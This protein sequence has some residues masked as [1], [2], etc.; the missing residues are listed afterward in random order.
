M[1][2]IN[3]QYANI[4]QISVQSPDIYIVVL[5]TNS[6]D[7]F[8]GSVYISCSINNRTLDD[9]RL[10]KRI[11]LLYEAFRQEQL[12]KPHLE[13]ILTGNFNRWDALWGGDKIVLHS[14]H[15]EG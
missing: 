8:L 7:L 2:W 9:L 4:Q 14:R 5:Q 15:G 10:E 1:I 6:R 12:S 13:F 11:N 3:K